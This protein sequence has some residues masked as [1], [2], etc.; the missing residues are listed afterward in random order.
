MTHR[1]AGIGKPKEV[2]SGPVRRV[3][4]WE[5]LTELLFTEKVRDVQEPG[6]WAVAAQCLCH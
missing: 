1:A 6:K 5:G 2:E 3:M 4:A